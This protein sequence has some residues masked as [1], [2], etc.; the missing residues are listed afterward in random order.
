MLDGHAR[1]PLRCW[2]SDIST[3]RRT[4]GGVVTPAT[5]PDASQAVVLDFGSA[6]RGGRG[7][8]EHVLECTQMYA[9]ARNCPRS[10]H[11][12]RPATEKSGRAPPCPGAGMSVPPVR[13]AIPKN[14]RGADGS[15][16]LFTMS[17]SKE[18]TEN[19]RRVVSDV[20]GRILMGGVSACPV[21]RHPPGRPVPVVIA[22]RSQ[23]NPGGAIQDRKTGC[24]GPRG[25]GG[26]PHKRP[27]G[28][29]MTVFSSRGW[30]HEPKPGHY[31]R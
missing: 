30:R 13:I 28:R 16:P 23:W 29:G 15:R 11:A 19:M 22:R 21:P 31:R 20:K 7:R 6:G 1:L 17:K 3:K 10:A 14:P 5:P 26:H 18:R 4:T 8:K 25:C 24:P 27:R 12:P 9:F 2:R